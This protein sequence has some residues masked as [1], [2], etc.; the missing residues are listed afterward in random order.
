M[1]LDP[2]SPPAV[3]GIDLAGVVAEIAPGVS[4]YRVGDE[5]YGMTGGVGG[6]QGSLAEYSAVDCDLLALR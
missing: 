2:P 1:R 3:L 6:L 4:R 5:V